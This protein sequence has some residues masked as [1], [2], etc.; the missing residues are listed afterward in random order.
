[1]VRAHAGRQQINIFLSLST[2]SLLSLK[3]TTKTYVKIYG[4]RNQRQEQL[5]SAQQLSSAAS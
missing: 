3:T 1:M 4:E 5:G 2:P